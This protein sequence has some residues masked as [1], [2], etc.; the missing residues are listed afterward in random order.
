MRGEVFEFFSGGADK[1]V[2]HKVSLP[3]HFHDETHSHAGIFVGAAEAVDNEEALVAEFLLGEVL[4]SLPG[5]FACGFVV[6][7]VFFGCPPDGV[8]RFFVENNKFVFRRTT[9][10]NACHY[11]DSAK[12]GYHTLLKSFE[13]RE[14][15]FIE[16]FVIRRVVNYFGSSFDTV[17]NEVFF[18]TCDTG[19]LDFF[20]FAHCYWRYLLLVFSVVI[21][22]NLRRGLVNRMQS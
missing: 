18:D 5:F 17:F 2:G 20:K 21:V 4:H 19:L 7:L 15:F 8:L 16:Q 14:S 22:L 10:V 6:V 9:G 3:C 11:V 1:H 13:G 12:F